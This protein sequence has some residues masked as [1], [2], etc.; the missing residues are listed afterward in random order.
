MTKIPTDTTKKKA[1]AVPREL[2]E[3]DSRCPFGPTF[4]L[5]Q[6]RAFVRD[7][8][9]N[10]SEGLPSVQLHLAEGEILD[11]CHIIGLA[12]RWLAVA[13]IESG[14]SAASHAMRTEII[15]YELVSRVSVRTIGPEPGHIGF[16]AGRNPELLAGGGSPEA[17]FLAMAGVALAPSKPA[18]PAPRG[19]GTPTDR[20]SP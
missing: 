9:P 5:M 7:R 12:P 14:R 3:Q 17:A 20:R 1:R 19:T 15:P 8:C 13:V 18:R 11:V 2:I 6:L 4:F 10:L 16:E